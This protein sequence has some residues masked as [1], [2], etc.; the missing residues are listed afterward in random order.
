M[1]RLFVDTSAWYAFANASA[2]RHE[3]V[4]KAIALWDGRLVTTDFIFDELLTLVRYRVGHSS[5]VAIGE[6]LRDGETCLLL[7]VETA[8]LELAWEQF[9]REKDQRFSFTDCTSFAV[10]RRIGLKAAAA[11]DE[12]FRRAGFAV[13]PEK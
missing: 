10:M 6:I 8:D 5:A 11:L 4:A 2:P 1:E 3:E 13:F 7:T 12:D 9:G